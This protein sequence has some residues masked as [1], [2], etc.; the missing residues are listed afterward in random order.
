MRWKPIVLLACFFAFITPAGGQR[1]GAY[2]SLSTN[3]TYL[4]GEKIGL[5][6]YASNVEELEFRVYKVNDPALFFERLDNPH[7]FGRAM[8]S[9]EQLDNPSFLERFHDWKQDLWETIRDFFRSQFSARS[10][11]QIREERQAK[12]EG[13]AGPT[14][15]VFAQAPVLNSSQL[16]ARWH[17][18]M[19]PRFYS[20]TENVPLQNLAKGAYLVEATD[21][22]LRAYTI[23]IVSELGLVTKTA[24]GQVLTFAADRRTG[25]P[26]FG[27]DVRVWVDK[28]EKANVKSDAS[29]LAETAIPAGQYQDVR[30][31]AVHDDDVALVTPYS[32]NLS[33]NPADD[34]TGY[35][36]T[37]RPVY[38]PTHTV[39]FKGIFRTQAGERFKVPAGEEVQVLIEDPD[40]KPVY[41]STLPISPFGTIQGD[42]NLS[43][44]AALGYYSISISSRG[45]QRYPI[46]GGFYVEEYKKPEYEVKVTP[47]TPRVLQGDFIEATIEAKYYFGEPVAG[48][49]VKYVVHT[50]PYW[51]PFI[52][53]DDDSGV[54][55]EETFGTERDSDDSGDYAGD[56]ISEQSGKLDADGKLT[57]RVPT[58]VN[59][60]H[61]DLRYRIEARVTDA[62]NREIAGHNSVIATYGSF[63][64]GVST[65]SY[66]YQVGDTIRATAVAKD[67]DGKPIQTAVHIELVRGYWYYY[68]GNQKET[69][70]DS[71][72]AVTGS[73]GTAIV[74]FRAREAGSLFLRVKAETPE[75]REVQDNTYLWIS[76][77]NN[78]WWGGQDREIRMVADKKSYKVGDTAHVLILTG[79]ADA[80]LLVT[81]EART[82]QTKRIVHATTSSVTLD[83][84]IT[85]DQQPNVFLTAAFIHDDKLYSASKSLK[86]PAVQQKLQ[87]EIQPSQ[88]Q[89][90]PGQKASYTIF[91]RDSDGKPVTGE[92]SIGVVDE[93]I[94]AIRPDTNGD[95]HDYFYGPVYD[96]VSLNSSLNFYFSGEA[97]KKQMF[98]AY[99]GNGGARALAQLKPEETLVQ[100]KVRKMFPDTAL[101]L[102]DVHTDAS[103]RAEAQLTFPD[104]LTTWRATVRGVTVDTKVGLATNDVIVRKN[105]MVRLAVPRFFRQ[106]D[107]VTVS[108]IVH[109]YLATAKTV[110]VS[111]D[112]KGLD[113]LAGQTTAV[114]VPSRGET[115][116]DWRVR[117]QSVHEAD[118]LAKALT[119]E[120]SDAMEITLPVIP[121][122]VKLTDAK[123]GSI[124][125][126]DQEENTVIILPGNPNQSS[127]T[128]D[129]TL[130][131]SLAGSIF[132]ALDY[133][134]S[135]PYGCTE[136]TMS[137]FLP[138]IV[139][140]KTMKELKL[141]STVDTPELEKKI[142]A[143][144]ARL[145][146][147][148]HDDG[149]WGWWKEDESQVFMTAYVVSGFGQAR[150][151]GYD[152]G[153][154]SLSRALTYLHSSLSKHP[155]MRYDLR[156]YVVYALALNNAAKPEELQDAWNVRGD[157]NTQGLALMG[158][159]FLSSG[160]QAKAQEI[161]GT[162]ESQAIVTDFE[163]SWPSA[164]DYMMEFEID[165]A[166]ET[167]AYA[168]RLLSLTKPASP[169]LPKAALW[170]VNHRE[171]GYFWYSTKQTAMVIFGLA[172][173]VRSSHEF[174]SN[175]RAEVYVNGK[176][177]I[178]RQF[179]AADSW[180]PV[181]PAIHLDASQLRIGANE[182]RIHK[183][184]TGRLYWSAAG[185]YYSNDKRLVQSNKL[186]LNIT[187]DYFRLTPEQL[188]G[189]IV[190]NPDPLHGDLHIGDILAVRVTVGGSEW[191]YLL[192][193]DPI[194]AGAEFITR[195]DLY[196]LKQ[197]PSWWEYWFTRREFHDDRAAIFQTYFSGRHEYVYLLKIVN[198]GKFQVSPAMVQ[199]MYQPSIMAT[200]DAAVVEVR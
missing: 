125:G 129:I 95:P 118:L 35:V 100:P 31:L 66:V 200:S 42:L 168:V 179:T 178:T 116:V 156:A 157:M 47:S 56:Q 3:K 71:S 46:N 41:Q 40:S 170:L 79:V 17:Q 177:V 82:I 165:D 15:D 98:L 136:Q 151:A 119:N 163:A 63:A 122:G 45:G 39:H 166:A 94:Y 160:D 52:E 112:L 13:H 54:M 34:W 20:E 159:A 74:T 167:T 57:V 185:A 51:S 121:V 145:K 109:N 33:S 24:E 14:A 10:R 128:L 111:L 7:D 188:N 154:D 148:Q 104:S 181:Q 77:T 9:K 195:D 138:D 62:G 5:R 76:S 84:P 134:T 137:S 27:A 130:S 50:L 48:A 2:F 190:Y 184:G 103:G 135:Y 187:R 143:G 197:R 89:F 132:S 161:A 114:G 124:A 182:I 70:L 49:D 164:Y 73:E 172:E 22:R 25:A 80:Y 23:V 91:A 26:V 30:V 67:Y 115:K 144:M 11:S 99:R 18:E 29:G 59:Q 28:K 141:Q 32:Y 107:E 162:M 58:R 88:K 192:M 158:L 81:T 120:E 198:P 131:P 36:Y 173:Y 44:T 123:S 83:V 150:E 155:N 1:P 12:T 68:G 142:Q 108:A 60:H 193:E 78:D 126:A 180:N 90:Q 96:R 64:V 113:I 72:D 101:W 191:R 146:D 87:I 105:L 19:P 149:G 194:P 69:I 199:P 169:L 43:A 65:E 6:V 139:V 175:F 92:F 106:G 152:P 153:T 133:L 8:A 176:Q 110:H 127:P 189:R 38:R 61:N 16:V 85:G 86:V 37:D 183:S 117:A 21:G 97:G 196:E 140:A 186:S 171:G 174:D 4:P 147:F 102:A 75:K 53:R 55:P 93:A